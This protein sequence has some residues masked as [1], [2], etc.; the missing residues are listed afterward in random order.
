MSPPG[1]CIGRYLNPGFAQEDL[2]MGMDRQARPIELHQS[3]DA[4]E[5]TEFTPRLRQG[6]HVGERRFLVVGLERLKQRSIAFGG[7]DRKLLEVPTS[8]VETA[9]SEVSRRTTLPCMPCS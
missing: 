7:S 1:G 2:A 9:G 4:I 5:T 3:F 6:E 8:L